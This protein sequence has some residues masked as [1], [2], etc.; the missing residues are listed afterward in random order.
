MFCPNCG[1]QVVD[2]SS[3]CNH[4][5]N[6]LETIQP[7]ASQQQV[8]VQQNITPQPVASIPTQTKSGMPGWQ[9]GVI[10]GLL[11]IVLL[12]LVILAIF[13]FNSKDGSIFTKKSNYNSRTIMIYMVG[14]NLEYDVRASSSDMAQVDPNT[15]D[16]TNTNILIY[17]GG[18]KYWH[19]EVRN[20]ENAIWKL[21][22]TGWMKIESYPKVSMI[23]GTELTK[24]LKYG[25]NNY[26]ADQYNLI[27]YDHGGA[28]YGAIQD[29]FNQGIINLGLMSQ[30]LSKS[31]F[32]GKHAKLNSVSFRACL[33]GSIEVAQALAPY[34]DYLV[35]SEEEIYLGAA[36]PAFGDSFNYLKASSNE[37][38]F[39]KKF[40]KA[41]D[42]TM[43]N[44]VDYPITY[45]II[46]LNKVDSL[47]NETNAF[48]NQLDPDKD[49]N[50]V[51]KARASVYQFPYDPDSHNSYDSIDLKTF[52]NELAKA[53]NKSADKF[54][55]VFDEA[56]VYNYTTIKGAEGLTIYFPYSSGSVYQKYAQENKSLKDFHNFALKVYN[57]KKTNGYKT[58]AAGTASTTVE[59]SGKEVVYELPDEIKDRYKSTNYYLF[60]RNEEHPNYYQIVVNS[61]DTEVVD[62]KVKIKIDDKMFYAVDDATGKGTYLTRVTTNTQGIKQ[63]CTYGIMSFK[64]KRDEY[65]LTNTEVTKVVFVDNNNKPTIKSIHIDSRNDNMTAG[66]YNIDD[67]SYAEFY[68]TERKILDKNGKVMDQEDWESIPTMT[69]VG[70]KMDDFDLQYNGMDNGEWYVLFMVTDVEGNTY[71]SELIKVGE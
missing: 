13:G 40:I 26:K 50:S 55:K 3:F 10:V 9:K 54:N 65:K 43:T 59:N 51:I 12:L 11:S 62:N 42:T 67:F 28:Y 34:A 14:T 57:T 18:T 60:R 7:V 68:K 37:E 48:I 49:Y 4:C 41:Y 53:T 56:I 29:D 46:D 27:M 23:D 19:N 70:F 38:D 36:V 25:Y 8:V 22:P 35:A 47:I 15:I 17:T 2:G 61:N 52:I 45:S 31:P 32:D 63:D 6:K 1:N 30:A 16:L 39:G 58:Y 71:N 66:V 21:T 64:E 33:M 69:G 24:F 44:K 20:D 5:G